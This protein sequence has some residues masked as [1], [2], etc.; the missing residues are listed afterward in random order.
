MLRRLV[1]RTIAQQYS[2]AV[3]RATSPFQFALSTRAGVECVALMT[4]LLTDMDDDAVVSSLDG[5]GAYD[6]VSRARFLEELAS[7]PELESILPF[8]RL[9]YSR[10]STYTWRDDDGRVHVI[11]QAE[12]VEQGDPLSPL[13]FS[14]AIHAA[15]RQANAELQPGE[16]LLAFLDDVY[17][18]TSKNRAAEVAHLVATTIHEHAG[19]EPKLGKFQLWGRRRPRTAGDRRS[20]RRCPSTKCAD[21]EGG[22]GRGAERHRHPRYASRHSG[23]RATLLG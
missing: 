1:A 2:E 13:L 6:H 7:S 23:V 22:L 21:L 14:L 12:G 3:L 11:R 20:P 17:T 9:W 8:V 16:Y 18:I 15:L 5:V 4:K 10:P 19:V